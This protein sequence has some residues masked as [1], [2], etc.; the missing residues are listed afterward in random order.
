MHKTTYTEA[1]YILKDHGKILNKIPNDK[2]KNGLNT[3]GLL[4]TALE[5]HKKKVENSVRGNMIEHHNEM[6]KGQT[7]SNRSKIHT[8]SGKSG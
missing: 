8:F 1:H 5:E 3:F 2:D 4:A 6:V 7:I